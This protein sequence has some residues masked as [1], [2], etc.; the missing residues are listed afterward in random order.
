M[1]AWKYSKYFVDGLI[2]ITACVC[3]IQIFL[4]S[5]QKTHHVKFTFRHENSI[6]MFN[7]SMAEQEAHQVFLLH[8]K[9]GFKLTDILN[10]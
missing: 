6:E 1:L 7:M 5:F 10:T 2:S 9:M 4:L 8:C 3:H